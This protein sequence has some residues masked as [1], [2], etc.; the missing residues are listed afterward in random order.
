MF[1]CTKDEVFE[2]TGRRYEL[3]G[4]PPIAVF[5]VDGE[6]F[7]TDDTCSHGNASLAE[8]WVEGDEVECPFHSGRFCVRDGRATAFP[9]ELP[10]RT[11]RSRCEGERVMIEPPPAEP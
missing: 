10:I 4:F 9:C 2:G 7:V 11:Y 8:G 3:P 1:V 5:N 6:F